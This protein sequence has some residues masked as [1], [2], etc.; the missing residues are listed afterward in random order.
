MQS[1]TGASPGSA[2]VPHAMK[3]T[4]L[5]GAWAFVLFIAG[6]DIYFAWQYRASFHLWE[7]NPLARWI[8]HDYGLTAVF[9]GKMFQIGFAVAVARYCHLRR[10]YLE[11][12]YTLIVSGIHLLLSVHCLMGH[13]LPI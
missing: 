12:P 7:L 5:V 13:V 3:N 2:E 4:L 9:V 8:A 10:H 1:V 11:L 6:Y